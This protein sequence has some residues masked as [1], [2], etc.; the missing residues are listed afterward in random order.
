M[1]AAAPTTTGQDAPAADEFAELAK[2]VRQWTLRPTGHAW[3]LV[4]TTYG[5]AGERAVRW[6]ERFQVGGCG[7]VIAHGDSLLWL[8]PP[9]TL[10]QWMHPRGLCYGRAF[11]IPVPPPAKRQGP[12]PHW[13]VPQSADRLIVPELLAHALDRFELAPPMPVMVR[14]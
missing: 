8:V 4:L 12:G 3:D 11:R 14:A 13:R 9:G 2:L 6:M 10:A 5:A 7:P 1:T